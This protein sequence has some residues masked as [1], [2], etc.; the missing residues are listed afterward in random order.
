M[1]YALHGTVLYVASFCNAY[2]T[3]R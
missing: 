1:Q 2:C 3:V